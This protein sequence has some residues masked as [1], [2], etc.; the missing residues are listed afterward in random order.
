MLD[1]F[2]KTI[3]F[4][5]IFL[6]SGHTNH[7]FGFDESHLEQLKRTLECSKCNLNNA[8]LSGANL[9]GANL[10]EANMRKANLL[11][12]NLTNAFLVGA[13]L[14]SINLVDANL[15]GANLTGANLHGAN[16]SAKILCKSIMPDRNVMDCYKS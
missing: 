8:D 7:L 4:T 5:L 16:V 10:N 14:F 2:S 12:T 11:Y 15:T 6:F 13:D 9:S 1:L 3:L